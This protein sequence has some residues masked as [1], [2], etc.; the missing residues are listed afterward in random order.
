MSCDPQTLV[1]EAACFSC[2][3]P[4]QRQLAII[5]LLCQIAE[6]GGGGGG[7]VDRVFHSA[8]DPNGIV[9]GPDP[10]I[11]Y[12]DDGSLW[13]K[14]NGATNNTGWE[15]LIAGDPSLSMM[16]MSAPP[17]DPAPMMMAMAAAPE[18]EP[19]ETPTPA[20]PEPAPTTM[21]KITTFLKSL[22]PFCWMLAILSF[23]QT[24]AALPP[25]IVRNQVTTN[26][27]VTGSGGIAVTQVG[28]DTVNFGFT[29]GPFQPASNTLSNW[30]NIPTN[31]LADVR[32]I[33]VLSNAWAGPFTNGTTGQITVFANTNSG[34]AGNFQ[35]ASNNLTNWSGIPTNILADIRTIIVETNTATPAVTNASGGITYFLVTN[36]SPYAVSV[37][38]GATQYNPAD[39]VTNFIGNPGVVADAT[40]SF[41]RTWVYAPIA[42]TITGFTFSLGRTGTTQSGETWQWGV[43]I[44]NTTDYVIGNL[45]GAA[46]SV[47]GLSIPV[48]R[49]QSISVWSNNPNWA[50][51]PT[52]LNPFGELIIEVTP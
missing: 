14:T 45:S 8:A 1:D 46:L 37:S 39:S 40:T 5:A 35:P 47:T 15:V 20:E 29:L 22:N 38:F 7:G 43:R 32:T 6:H 52:A 27:F 19:T 13:V 16:S 9:V 34:A 4:S 12:G 41:S 11:C 17:E 49:G 24:A 48:T 36:A 2:I 26:Y 10:G 21:S 30:S 42:G 3:Q 18:L 31:V 25:P 28:T 23:A 33:I 50:T 51:N 44:A